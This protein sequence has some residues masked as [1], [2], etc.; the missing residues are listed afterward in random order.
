MTSKG[1]KVV[2]FCTHCQVET[3][4][5]RVCPRC[6][7]RGTLVPREPGAEASG[8]AARAKAS[9]RGPE[10]APRQGK[11]WNRRD[12][13]GRLRRYG[14]WLGLGALGVVLGLGALYFAFGSRGDPGERGGGAGQES[15]PPRASSSSPDAGRHFGASRP[16][17][18]PPPAQAPRRCGEKLE[19]R[20]E[21]LFVEDQNASPPPASGETMAPSSSSRSPAARPTSPPAARPGAPPQPEA[22]VTLH[23]FL[24]AGALPKL[25]WVLLEVK[26]SIRIGGKE[27]P[28]LQLGPEGAIL[29]DPRK[30]KLVRHGPEESFAPGLRP[31]DLVGQPLAL[32][33]RAPSGVLVM[34]RGLRSEPLAQNLVGDPLSLVAWL[35]PELPAPATP[36]PRRLVDSRP[37]PKG[38]LPSLS[39]PRRELRLDPKAK[40][41]DGRRYLVEGSARVTG[42]EGGTKGRGASAAAAASLRR[43]QGEVEYG[44]D[45]LVPSLAKLR[46]SGP[47]PGKPP[48]R[49]LI[50]E[51]RSLGQ[52]CNR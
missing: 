26:Q 6:H 11:G 9:A 39:E 7:R 3:A 8:V 17:Q 43:F 27:V 42:G 18:A 13:G 36:R 24:L 31:S 15:P 10:S 21:V 52:A 46:V 41:G 35:T 23:R 37:M 45:A 30:R 12:P 19:L 22:S 29:L 51:L 20:V 16:G 50:L 2:Y 49:E 38:L 28:F 33:G 44:I 5:A 48:V 47:I 14:P 32:L 34:E 4:L 40:P 1:V 25:E